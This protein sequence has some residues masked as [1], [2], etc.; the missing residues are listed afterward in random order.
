M[1]KPLISCLRTKTK[2]TAKYCKIRYSYQTEIDTYQIQQIK[3][4]PLFH[5]LR[6][7]NMIS[8]IGPDDYHRSSFKFKKLW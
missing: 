8:E 1:G 5:E 7:Q 6:I 3:L 2:K 4:S